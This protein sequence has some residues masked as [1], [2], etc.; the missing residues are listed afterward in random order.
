MS[1]DLRADTTPIADGPNRYRIQLPTNWDYVLPSGGVVMTAALRAAEV[2][3]AEPPLRFASATTIF[4]T[5]IHPGPLVAEVH[6]LRRGRGA[7]QV[8]VALHHEK[9]EA[10]EDSGMELIATFLRERRGPDVIAQQ[11]PAWAYS[12]ADALP[13]DDGLPNNPHTRFPFFHQFEC[14][15]AIPEQFWKGDFEA[16]PARYARWF[17][18]KTPQRDTDGNLDRLALPP[19]IDTM[20]P[21]LHRAVGP[22]GYRFFAPSLDLTTYAVDDTKRDWLLVVSELK[23]ARAGWG[24]ADCQVWDDEGR[25]VAYGTQAMYIQNLSGEPPTLDASKR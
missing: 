9:G 12:L 8:R 20:P 11:P 10:N 6:V 18:Y 21:A 25:F 17:R 7:T 16:G 3:L 23:R 19:I 2:H 1:A 5:P 22:S 13:T 14:K 24:V 4:T 15:L